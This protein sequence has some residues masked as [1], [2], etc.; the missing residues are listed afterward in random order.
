MARAK[1]DKLEQF[2]SFLEGLSPE[3]RDVIPVLFRVSAFS[4]GKDD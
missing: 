2:Q 3:E 4:I 1:D